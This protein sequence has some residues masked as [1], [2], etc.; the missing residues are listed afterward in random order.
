[1][2]T[3]TLEISKPK[4]AEDFEDYCA[5]IYSVVFEDRT[6]KKNGRSG[7]S[8]GGV[9]IFVEPHSGGRKGIQCKRYYETKVTESLVNDEVKAADAAGW[10]INEL[11]IATTT[12]SD[13]KLVKYVQDLSDSRVETGKF[14]V[15]IEFWNDICNQINRFQ[16]LQK[17]YSPNAPGGVF[18]DIRTSTEEARTSA[19]AAAEGVSALVAKVDSFVSQVG[20]PSFIS[21]LSTNENSVISRQ[22]DKIVKFVK[23]MG[24]ASAKALLSVVFEEFSTLNAHQQARWYLLSGIVDWHTGDA[25]SAVRKFDTAYDTYPEDDR[26]CAGKI[27]GLLLADHADQAF[28]IAERAISRF[29]D[30]IQVWLAWANTKIKLAQYLVEADLPAKFQADADA[31][32]MM[33]VSFHDAGDQALSLAYADR[34]LRA[35]G[36]GFYTWSNVLFI[37][38]DFAGKVP[39]LAS[40]GLLPPEVRCTLSE[41]CERF[42]P[43][44][45]KLWRVEGGPIVADVAVNLA[46]GRLLLGDASACL[47]ICDEAEAHCDSSTNF[48]VP[49]VYAYHALND[50]Q[51]VVDVGAPHLAD[52]HISAQMMVGEAAAILG[53]ADVVGHV[54][55]LPCVASD[56]EAK[57]TLQALTWVA[58]RSAGDMAALTESLDEHD[59]ESETA[60][61]V[62]NTAARIYQ[63]IGRGE[64][65]ATIGAKIATLVT[66]ASATPLKIQAA[67]TFAALKDYPAA[68]ARL[69]SIPGIEHSREL[70]TRLLDAYAKGGYR[71]KARA[72][73]NGAPPSWF[74]DEAFISTAIVAAQQANDWARLEPLALQHRDRCPTSASAWEF[75]Y[76]V[77]LRTLRP[78][79]IRSAFSQAP[80]ELNGAPH[81]VRRVALAELQYGDA[82]LGMRRLYRLFR[83]NLNDANVAAGYITA[84]LSVEGNLMG[85]VPALIS[86]GVAATLHREDGSS[87]TLVVDPSDV[88]ALPEAQNY[89][90]HDAAF[91]ANFIGK[92]VGDTVTIVHPMGEDT[93]YRIDSLVPASRHLLAYAHELIEKSVEPIPGFLSMSVEDGDGN[94]DMS[95]IHSQLKRVTERANLVLDGYRQGRLTVGLCAQLLGRSPVEVVLGW[96]RR[97]PPLVVAEGGADN[98]AAWLTSLA[99]SSSCV[100]DCI[101][102]VELGLFKALPV[103]GL[104]PRP[105]VAQS[106]YDLLNNA[107][108]EAKNER[109]F[110]H[111]AEVDGQLAM[112]RYTP[113]FRRSKVELLTSIIECVERHCE[114][115]P[116]YGPEE[117]SSNFLQFKGVLDDESYDAIA[118]CLER[119]AELIS[120]D[121]RFRALALS[122]FEV[123][124]VPPLAAIAHAVAK[125]QLPHAEHRQYLMQL[126]ASNRTYVSIA[127]RDFLWM[128]S[129]AGWT[130]VVLDAWTEV[131]SSAGTL[132]ES[133]VRAVCGVF[134]VLHLLDIQF[135][136]VHCLVERLCLA[137]YRHP[138]FHPAAAEM[139]QGALVQYAASVYLGPPWHPTF[140]E[141]QGERARELLFLVEDA[142]SRAKEIAE[143]RT[144]AAE[145]ELNSLYCER[146]PFLSET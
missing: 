123:S 129:Q 20:G 137:I 141:V 45:E 115:A 24:F 37:A 19:V 38:T 88:G 28:G 48:T 87:F 1:M 18:D 33:A 81:V 132:F 65:A 17:K 8:Q 2:R 59:F 112:V 10:R 51:H 92:A 134:Q 49:R 145:H 109:A 71:A 102:L 41:V 114:I 80:L 104:L 74:D 126:L 25:S 44:D 56:L 130:T 72:I 121:A 3:F 131:L 7:Q 89:Y 83:C 39:F 62:L 113:E 42:E 103:V 97:Q 140:T 79:E 90:P 57:G 110:G 95:G 96:G 99:S 124:A 116:A 118:L 13:S 108:E 66:A 98:Q 30:S 69:V 26:I 63:A 32:Q 101:T 78:A 107:L 146:R 16:I 136:V 105:I 117:V 60:L 91:A 127:A 46:V 50:H 31:L 133:A 111:T 86:A 40:L 67:D 143:G 15:S 52:M 139:M 54:A 85:V 70:Q 122:G 6:P 100:L 119:G 43:R 23:E 142:M 21:S 14:K 11:I 27:R 47:A 29:P 58:L 77:A 61:I 135:G 144:V 76:Q 64:K 34:A 138:S 73:V 35:E 53:R 68:I 5:E 9:D 84:L 4:N 12:P 22:L 93:T 106:A 75:W 82:A 120:L 125:G 36:A 128:L 55:A 94:V